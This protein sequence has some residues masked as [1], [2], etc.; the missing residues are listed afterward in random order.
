MPSPFTITWD[1]NCV[2]NVDFRCTKS[3]FVV[4]NLNYKFIRNENGLIS[5]KKPNLIFKFKYTE[6]EILGNNCQI[7]K[8]KK[9]EKI[10]S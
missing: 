2:F 4:K 1:L 7:A 5:N 3:T 6:I 10:N 8:Y 9:S